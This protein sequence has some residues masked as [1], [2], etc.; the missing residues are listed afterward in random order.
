MTVSDMSVAKGNVEAKKVF[1]VSKNSFRH[2]LSMRPTLK[3]E[4][5]I[6]NNDIS[7]QD[8]AAVQIEMDGPIQTEEMSH[9]NSYIYQD[10]HIHAD[11]PTDVASENRLHSRSVT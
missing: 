9:N 5:E 8:A 6:A 2:R 11:L 3:P 7:Q 4:S 10:D 1:I